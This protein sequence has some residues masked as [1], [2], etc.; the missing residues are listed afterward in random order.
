MLRPSKVGPRKLSSTAL[1]L[2]HHQ[3]S[4]PS[5]AVLRARPGLAFDDFLVFGTGG[6]AVGRIELQG[7]IIPI[8][9]ANPTYIGSRS[10]VK[11]GYVVGSGVE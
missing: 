2:S 8:P 6:L 7:S 1:K 5:C 9:A 4:G 10:L 3:G 11:A